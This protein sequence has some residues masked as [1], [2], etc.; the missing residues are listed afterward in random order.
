MIT[1]TVKRYFLPYFGKKPINAINDT[2]VENYWD[3]RINYWNSVEGLEK[4]GKAQKSRTTKNKPYKNVLGNVAKVAKAKERG[5]YLGRK[6]S[7]DVEMV[8]ELKAEGMGATAIARELEIDRTNVYRVLRW[9]HFIGQ[10]GSEVKVY[11]CF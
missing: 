11:S 3:W 9:S 7:I 8:K 5:V 6:P 4:I 2:F 10:F 1:G